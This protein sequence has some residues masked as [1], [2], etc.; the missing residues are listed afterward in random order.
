LKTIFW[1]PEQAQKQFID[2]V[3]AWFESYRDYGFDFIYIVS[4]IGWFNEKDPK[5][6]ER[7]ADFINALSELWM[8][9]PYLISEIRKLE[10]SEEL[11]FY[12]LEDYWTYLAS[13]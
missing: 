5:T 12:K 9:I 10:G 2:L 7:K 13:L 11:K 3:K 8:K 4:R 6:W 1:L